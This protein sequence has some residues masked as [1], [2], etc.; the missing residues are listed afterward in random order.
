MNGRS[1]RELA[2]AILEGGSFIGAG[3]GKTV[4][5]AGKRRH[6][7]RLASDTF[8]VLYG[9]PPIYYPELEPELTA[10]VADFRARRAQGVA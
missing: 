8:N 7:I 4:T 5:V 6:S 1:A 9:E 10:A 2:L 3:L